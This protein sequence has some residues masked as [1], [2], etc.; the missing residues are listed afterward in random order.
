MQ[1]NNSPKS[2]KPVDNGAVAGKAD[3]DALKA[4]TVASKAKV[5]GVKNEIAAFRTGR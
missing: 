1:E 2:T 3:A 5:D 4:S